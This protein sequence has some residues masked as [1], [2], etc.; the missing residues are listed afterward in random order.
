MMPTP[1]VYAYEH[2]SRG[3]SMYVVRMYPSV[4]HS[5][6]DVLVIALDNARDAMCAKNGFHAAGV[7]GVSGGVD[8]VMCSCM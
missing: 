6:R 4:T 3:M 2:V 8:G 5:R 1:S 7:G